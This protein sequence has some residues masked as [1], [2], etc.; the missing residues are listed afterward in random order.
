MA[1]SSEP[2]MLYD[3]N[4][5]IRK[6][7]TDLRNHSDR[8][9]GDLGLTTSMRAVLEDLHSGGMQTVPD[10]A[11][12]KNVSR[13]HIQQ[14]ADALVQDGFAVF[15]DNPGHKRSKLRAMTAKGAEAYAEI[16]GREMRALAE[17]GRSIDPDEVKA[18]IATLRTF[19]RLLGES[20]V[21]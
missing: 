7:F 1:R 20:P 16:R 15:Q 2:E 8:E 5:E 17:A 13:Q 18:S 19:R 4:T 9:I 11:R 6:A 3:L 12:G 10:I 21:D 14:L